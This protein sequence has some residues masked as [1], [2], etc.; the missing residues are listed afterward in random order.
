MSQPKTNDAGYDDWLD[1]WLG[2]FE[3]YYGAC[4]RPPPADDKEASRRDMRRRWSEKRRRLERVRAERWT[5][6]QLKAQ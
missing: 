5:R 4:D 3:A 1:G 6:E 2:E